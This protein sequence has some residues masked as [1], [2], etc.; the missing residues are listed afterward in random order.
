MPTTEDLNAYSDNFVVV[1]QGSDQPQISVVMPVYNCEQFVVEAVASVLSQQNVIAEILISDDASTDNTFLLAYKTV[2]SYINMHG[3][4]HTVLIRRGTKRLV[5]DH[6]HLIVDRA[7]CDIVCQAHGDDISHAFRCAALV[8]AFGD[9]S[10]KISMIFVDAQ[11]INQQGE[12]LSEARKFSLSKIPLISVD[13]KSIM[14]ASSEQLIGSNM[15]WRKSAFKHF[16]QLSTSYCTYGHDRV[17]AFRAFLVGG[18]YIIH[19]PL[20]K[21][22]L[23]DNN[24]HKEL[25]AN[26]HTP[27]NIFNGQ[28]IR[29][30]FLMAMKKDLVFLKEHSLIK[31]DRFRAINH[32]IALLATHINDFLASATNTLVIDGYVNKWIKEV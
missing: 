25:T 3:S 2:T 26:D 13:Y 10:K 27:I 24:L 29:L 32:D 12:L 23:H 21:R 15:A 20:L 11:P 17:M 14:M 16:T 31:E 18:C 30:S 6:L 1:H 5:R 7:C 9:P 22:R 8:N 28:L 19:A 4:K